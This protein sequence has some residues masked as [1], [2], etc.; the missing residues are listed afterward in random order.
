MKLLTS[1]IN[2]WLLCPLVCSVCLVGVCSADA[3]ILGD[4]DLI[5]DIVSGGVSLDG[6]NV[7]I[8]G[9]EI[10]S[11][12]GSLIAVNFSGSGLTGATAISL[13]QDT[14]INESIFPIGT[15][16]TVDGIVELGNIYDT[17]GGTQELIFRWTDENFQTSVESAVYVPE[18]AGAMLL[19]IAGLTILGRR[20]R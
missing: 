1:H 4:L 17:V 5:V 14:N 15:T 10:Q 6:G 13:P 18:P 20:R 11:D 19:G 2:P 9:W 7:A 8:T 12:D 16:A 3:A